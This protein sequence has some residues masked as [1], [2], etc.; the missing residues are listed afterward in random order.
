M[1]EPC[2]AL[3]PISTFQMEE[4]IRQLK[5]TYTAVIVTHNMQQAGRVAEQTVFLL[6]GRL[7]EVGETSHL[8]EHSKRK[9]KADLEGGLTFLE[10]ASI[11]SREVARSGHISYEGRPYFFSKSLAGRYMRLIVLADR[12]IID[13]AIPLHKKYPLI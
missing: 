7:I 2:S 4:L 6:S 13:A 5:A 10:G 3:D 9:E 11:F 1:D 12:L 8:F